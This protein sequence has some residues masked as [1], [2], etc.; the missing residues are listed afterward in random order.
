MTWQQPPIAAAAGVRR[1]G[2]VG[3]FPAT[4]RL[5]HL[6][7]WF[8]AVV[9]AQLRIM[10]PSW[11]VD[12]FVSTRGTIDGATATFGAPFYGERILGQLV[13]AESKKNHSHC[14]K[15]DYDAPPPQED[16]PGREDEEVRLIQIFLVRR[17]LCS[18]T[19]KVKVARE[20]GAHAVIVVDAADSP[21]TREDIQDMIVADDGYGS[22]ISVPSILLSKEDGQKLID[23]ARK[24]Q[25]IVE[26][27]WDVP[28][29]HIV[30]LDLWMSS[31]ARDTMR[32]L[33]EFAP[34][35]KALN[36]ALSFAP[37]YHVFRMH[38]TADYQSLCSDLSAEFCSEDPDGAGPITGAMVLDE[39]V[40]QLCIH[41]ITQ[42]KRTDADRLKLAE[43]MVKKMTGAGIV[44]YAAKFWDY[45]EKLLDYCPVD[46]VDDEIERFGRECSTRLMQKVGIDV[47]KVNHCMA[48]TRDEKLRQQR[49][50][51]AWSP[52]ALRINGWRYSGTLDADLVMRAICAGFVSQPPECSKLVEPVDPFRETRGVSPAGAIDRSTFA[53]VLVGV[54]LLVLCALCLYRRS[55]TRQVHTALREEVM[56]EV[57][58]QMSTYKSLA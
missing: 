37:H 56:L 7:V 49:A 43:R 18:F 10:S 44:D 26:L 52:R 23:A 41:E 40:R 33:A 28:S 53:G 42:V 17:G 47:E 25:V 9:E 12:E 16:R 1:M 19:A 31:G 30:A 55:I 35:R 48:T 54:S 13:W 15:E 39:D 34:K 11:L 4:A 27:A 8:C 24:S 3:T 5:R 51:T 2:A 38:Q 29:N 21:L 50:N 20:K 36:E 57:Q 14:L 6:F 46:A 32:F 45:V 22:E 58:C